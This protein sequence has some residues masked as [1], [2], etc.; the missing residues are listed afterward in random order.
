MGIYKVVVKIE[1]SKMDNVFYME[2]EPKTYGSLK[3][4]T[5]AGKKIADCFKGHANRIYWI[6][7]NIL[8]RKDKVVSGYTEKRIRK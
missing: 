7:V 5:D 8:N 2:L 6:F 4:A 1:D 3:E